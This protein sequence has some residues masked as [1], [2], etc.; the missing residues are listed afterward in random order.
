MEGLTDQQI[1]RLSQNV[2]DGQ[3]IR[4][5]CQHTGFKMY[6]KALADIIA[7]HKNAWLKGSDEDA[8]IERIRAQGIQKAIDVLKQFILL[9]DNAARMLN[10]D[11]PVID[12]K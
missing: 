3:I 10:S 8:K 6:E 4:S 2:N 11:V 12:E 1:A 5:F 9:G 7:D